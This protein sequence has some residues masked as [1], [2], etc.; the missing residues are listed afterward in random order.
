MAGDVDGA[1]DVARD[2]RLEF[3]AR[4]RM[5]GRHARKLQPARRLIAIGQLLLHV[6]G[7]RQGGLDRR[8]VDLIVQPVLL[9]LGQHALGDGAIEIVAAERGIAA[10]RQDLEHALLQPQQGEVEGAAT[11]IVDRVEA[12]RPLVQAV[13][14]C[15]RRRL[16]DQAQNFQTGDARGIAGRRA[17]GVVEIGRHG[18]DRTFD[19]LVQRRL[20]A[21]AQGL[22]DLGRDLDRRARLAGDAQLHHVGLAAARLDLVGQHAGHG[23]EIGS[24]A[25]HQPFDRRHDVARLLRHQKTGF[26]AHQHAAGRRIGHHRRHHGLAGLVMQRGGLALAGD[27]HHRV[28]RAEIDADRQRALAG[29]RQGCFARLV[30][31]QQCHALDRSRFMRRARA[32]SANLSR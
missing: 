22:Q 29:M 7:K 8:L 10:G 26:V 16:V 6:A 19:R 27:R 23:V 32:S 2:H 13:G 12:L 4:Q 3:G 30:D 1:F 28:G 5:K 20:G 21:L 31:L 25:A 9:A 18:D 24:A 11:E 17:R 14:Q 15:C